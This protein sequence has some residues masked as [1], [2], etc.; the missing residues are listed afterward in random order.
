MY[1][2]DESDTSSEDKS[3][4]ISSIESEP[5]ENSDESEE[6]VADDETMAVR[7]IKVE[8]ETILTKGGAITRRLNLAGDDDAVDSYINTAINVI[9]N[10]DRIENYN[11][12]LITL[13][14]CYDMLFKG[15]MN[16]KNI[17]EF[18]SL[19]IIDHIYDPIDIIRYVTLY[20]SKK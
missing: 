4:G 8:L 15:I 12:E 11:V 18:V 1:N 19:K 13:A 17:T 10:L 5:S 14:A 6:E 3:S 20:V 2:E 9:K 7:K 16:E